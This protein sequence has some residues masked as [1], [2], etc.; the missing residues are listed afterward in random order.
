M[1]MKT[2]VQ[3]QPAFHSGVF[4][5]GVVVDDQ[6]D[7]E[8]LR[9]I[10]IDVFEEVEI[11]LVAMPLLTL[12]EDFAG[13]DVQSRE[14]GQGSVPH[15]VVGDALHISQTHGQNRLSP[16]QCLNLAFLIDTED[17]GIFR[18][19]EIESDDVPDFFDEKGIGRDFEMALPVRLQAEGLPDSLDSGSRNGGFFG[20]GAD[21]PVGAT[22]GLALESFADEFGDL[23]I[24]N[25]AGASGAELIVEAGY[26][27][28][29]ITFSPQGYRL[30]AVV[31]LVCDVTIGQ[32]L[33][34]HQD[35]LRSGD[36]AVR[37]G[38][39]A[40]DGVEFQ[41]FFFGKHNG[42]SW[43]SC[44]HGLPPSGLAHD[45]KKILISQVIYDTL[46]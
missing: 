5:G 24:G 31:D 18:G 34:R 25:G 2:G 21:R 1:D 14:K 45:S 10:G 46:H 37:Q 33:G 13:G 28:F 19:V 38:S 11:V 29:Q 41:R 36:Q 26:S 22:F 32:A 3:G 23:F 30:S 27:L 12:G 20:H 7:G 17:H 15:I 43:S 9:D 35:N 16:V 44:S 4:M 6:M 42:F 8:L 40:C 39:R